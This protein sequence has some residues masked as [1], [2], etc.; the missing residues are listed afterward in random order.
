MKSMLIKSLGLAAGL[1][2]TGCSSEPPTEP[3]PPAKDLGYSPSGA[4]NIPSV[5]KAGTDQHFAV[6]HEVSGEW[7]GLFK[8]QALDGLVT[9]AIAG[10][11]DLA[12]AQ[13]NL[14]A[15]HEA[16]LVAAGGLYPQVD[17]NASGSRQ[18]N[19]FEAFGINLFPPKEFNTFSLGPA[20]SYS[21]NP[22]GPT[23]HQ[24]ERQ[25]ALEDFQNH[26]LKAAYLTLTGSAVTEAIAIASLNAQIK[27]VNDMLADDETNLKLVQDMVRAGAGTDLDIQ[28]A[29]SQLATDRT[30]LPPLRQQISVAQHALAVLVGKTPASWQPPEFEL[31]QLTLPGQLPVSLPSALVRQR[32]DILEAEA[33][34]RA[35]AA[36]VG[37]ANAALYPQFTLTADVLQTFLKPERIFDPVSN[38][39][40]VGANLA[41]PIFHGGTLQAQKREA[42][43][44]YDASVATYTQTVLS[45]VGQVADLLDA[46]A[47]DAEELSAQQTAYNAA[48]SAVQL[49]RTSFQLGN[50]TLL[51]VLD[52]QRQLQQAALGVA[53]AEGQRFLDSTQLFVALGGGWWNRP[54]PAAALTKSAP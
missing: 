25:R 46:L 50:T 35:S 14:A 51:Q 42:L 21:F 19:N 41:A 12:V 40:A 26:E 36:S 23:I 30:Q 48:E 9:Q 43:H 15:A 10:N 18:R 24:V 49:T 6:G 28:T 7:W 37:I 16:V 1:L 13:A 2:V 38:V 33:Q 45:A 20:V 17:F 3:P 47:H 11:Q 54:L 8:S 34:F 39:W 29:N 32:P 31:D 22:A 52:T 44:T 5:G 4:P 27:A 53:R